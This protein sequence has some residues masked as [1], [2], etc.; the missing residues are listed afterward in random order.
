MPRETKTTQAPPQ[1]SP[2]DINPKPPFQEQKQ[3]LPGREAQLRPEADHGEDS[4]R[5][6][7][8]LTDK[9]AIITGADSGIGRAVALAYAREGADVLISYMDEE[10]DARETERLVTEAGRK[11]VR[12]PGDI[13]D[14]DTCQRIVQTALDEFGHIEILVNNAAHQRSFPSLPE[15]PLDEIERT[16]RTNIF[17]MFYL[18]RAAVPSMRPGSAVINTA[19]IEAYQP[20]PTLL[21]YASTKGA[22]VAFTKGLAKMLA[23]KGI[24]VNAV[25][26][27]P[28]WTPLI[29][30]SMDAQN[31]SQFGKS[32]PMGR[33][34][35]P[36]ELAPIYVLLAS[37]AASYM[38]G[39]VYDVTGGKPTA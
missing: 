36:Y 12:V 32:D 20:E 27:G 5:G 29:P 23:E 17:A 11:A 6:C 35:Q 7:G 30:A 33:P 22:V 13:G 31:V 9:A 15:L 3:Q 2:L 10:D 37:D 34:A 16:F 28:V 26:P 24:R 1:A 25:A 4:Y 39:G 21:T 18:C 8:K 14:P 19:S 38:S